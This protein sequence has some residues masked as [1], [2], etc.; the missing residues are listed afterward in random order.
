MI[1]SLHLKNFGPYKDQF[2]EFH[3]GVNVFVGLSSNGKSALLKA[4]PFVI[5]NKNPKSADGALGFINRPLERGKVAEVVLSLKN[6]AGDSDGSDGSDGS[7]KIIRRKGKSINEY[8]LNDD[9]PQKAMGVNVPAHISQIINMNSINFHKQKDLPFLLDEKPGQVA[10]QLSQVINLQE[11]DECTSLAKSTVKENASILKN[12]QAEL[13]NLNGSLNDL[14]Y[15][16]SFKAEVDVYLAARADFIK[17]D[18]KFR[19]VDS[20]IVEIEELQK[21]QE[22]LLLI[23]QLDNDICEFELSYNNFVSESDRFDKIVEIVN[24]LELL[25]VKT[26]RCEKLILLGTEIEKVDLNK[27]QLSEQKE[28]CENIKI[29]VAKVKDLT[30]QS[31]MSIKVEAL[32]PGITQLEKLSIDYSN[33]CNKFNNI[34]DCYNKL[35]ELN[36]SQAVLENTIKINSEKLSKMQC[37]TCGR[38]S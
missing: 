26:S 16:Q 2:V 31:E 30:Q 5:D 22:E 36:N 4:F 32:E 7:D 18:N 1:Q 34:E 12:Q 3:S 19:K 33:N 27:K 24:Q 21:Q 10:K 25:V 14:D 38:K 20:I 9:T 37:P 11:I 6:E 13:E 17:Q 23:T 29:C 28:K 35:G 8:Q 15:V